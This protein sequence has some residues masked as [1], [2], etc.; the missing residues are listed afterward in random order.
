MAETAPFRLE[1][2]GKVGRL[3]FTRPQTRNA[4]D[5][6]FW[7]KLP[8]QVRELD[9]SGACRCL[10]ISAE[11]PH[12]TSGMDLSVFTRPD[13]LGA[14]AGGGP[15]RPVAME[16]FRHLVA[17]LQRSFTVL[18]QA[19]FP[20]LAAVQGGCIGAG[21]DLVSACDV[22]YAT[23]GA[24]FQLQEINIG[25]TADVGAFPRLC[26]LMP[27][28]AVREM[29]YTGRRL[30]AADA[31]RLGLVTAVLPD[32][33][34]LEAHVME[35]AREIAAKAPLAITGSKVMMTYARDHSTA[36]ALDYVALWQTGMLSA[37][38]MVEALTAR[39]QGREPSFPDLAP[40]REGL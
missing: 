6:A 18:E 5:A 10:V 23:E 2:D 29:A 1:L 36:D 25:M 34:A 21:V 22:R 40:V 17:A 31:H 11:G 38:Q 16:A 32:A 8:R 30:P 7:R 26:R 3:V 20:V 4:M 28:G 15:N 13:G 39:T 12:F 14:A 27:E 24:F 19:R 35:V 37:A 9:A 33:E